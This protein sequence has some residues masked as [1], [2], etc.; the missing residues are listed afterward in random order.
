MP[1]IVENGIVFDLFA[2]DSKMY[3]NSNTAIKSVKDCFVL[4]KA[5]VR[6][7]IWTRSWQLNLNVDKCLVLHIGKANPQYVYYIDGSPLRAP[8]HVID[9]GITTSKS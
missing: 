9:L 7:V 3:C 8:E 4:K 6:L 1:D 5:L 2:D